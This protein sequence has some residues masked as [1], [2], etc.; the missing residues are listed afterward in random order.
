MKA[1]VLEKDA[2]F[3]QIKE[4]ERPALAA[5]MV[6]VKVHACGVCGSDV[7]LVLHRSMHAKSYPR[8]P[9]HESSGVV[10]EVGENVTR[11][12]PQDRVV[13]SAGT[14]CGHC[15]ACKAGR[16]NLCPEVGVLGFDSDGSFAEE[17]V[18][19]ERCLFVFS[20]HI[21]FEQAAILADA[22][23]TPYHAL[24][25]AG[26]IKQG[27]TVAVF[28]CGG[29]GIHGVLLARALGASRVF[30]LDVEAGALSNAEKAGA[31]EIID[32]S[33]K[34]S[35]GKMN[36][37]K[38]LKEKG[39][40]D[41]V[42]DFSGYYSNIEESVRAMNPGGRM[43]MVGLGRN[44]LKF[45]IPAT[46]IFKMISVCGSYGSDSRALPE[47]IDLL[48]KGKINLAPSITSTHPLE[49]A[50]ECIEKL[51]NRKGNPIR[52]VIRP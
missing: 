13:V 28:G 32:L 24:R 47:L 49:E 26:N 19:P 17:V 1:A 33:G 51:E 45:A 50:Q 18:V 31:N 52:F 7:H 16:E 6:R 46:L 15:A 35:V 23:S 5:G 11:V 20:S 9:G 10:I 8:I 48:E 39:G 38:I 36:A 2:R 42:V 21:P 29:L 41:L 12:K 34:S 27:D 40:V 30:A 25:Y 44:P 22:V 43:V 3:L 37:G 14:S 4:V